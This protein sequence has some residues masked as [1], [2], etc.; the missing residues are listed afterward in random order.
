MHKQNKTETDTQR[1][2]KGM[3]TRWERLGDGWEGEGEIVNNIVIS[4]L[5]DRELR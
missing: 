4:L 3:V 5:R 2:T 1:E